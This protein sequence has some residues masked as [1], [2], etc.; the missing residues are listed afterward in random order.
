MGWYSGLAVITLGI[1]G[2]APAW[3]MA[4][5]PPAASPP[6]AVVQTSAS[7]AAATVNGEVI[8]EAAVQRELKFAAPQDVAKLR[9]AIVN[10]L[11]ELMLIDQYLRSA[12]VEASA[13]EIESRFKRMQEEAKKEGN[14]DLK[15]LLEKLGVSEQELRTMLTADLRWENF[16]K[17][18]AD[19]TKLETF[20]NGNKIMFDGSE[21]H[22]RHVLIAVKADAPAAEKQ[23]AQAKLAG[24]KAGIL[25]RADE[26]AAKNDPNADTVTKSKAKLENLE[27][28]F[29]E[30][31]A[32]ES[33]CPSKKN[34]G[35]LGFFPRIGVMVDGFAAAAFALEAGT[36]TE[37]V[38]TQ[39]GYHVILCIEKKPGKEVKFADLKEPVRE[40]YGEKLKQVMVPQLK[41]RAQIVISPAP[42]VEAIAPPT[43]K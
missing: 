34:G 32:K 6:Q 37:V 7:G 25:K 41:Q 8:S 10:N 4:Q 30:V 31:A 22:G 43:G 15:Q 38:E 3:L 21:V 17:S 11:V 24:L 2:W 9:P 27:T 26:L 29:A 18:Q 20:F 40:V 16:V 13:E 36:M 5:Q 1:V 14:M 33:D 19:D 42:A 35:D 28:A 12:K 39:F 23:A